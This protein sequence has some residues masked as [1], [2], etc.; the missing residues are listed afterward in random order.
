M[1]KR[2]YAAVLIVCAAVVWMYG[3]ALSS[4]VSQWASDD[5]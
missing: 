5:D 3:G 1:N 2:H 4:L